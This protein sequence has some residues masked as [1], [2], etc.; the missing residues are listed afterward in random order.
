MLP[1]LP[2]QHN[3]IANKLEFQSQTVHRINIYN[4][5]A[6]NL[7][8]GHCGLDRM[9]VGFITTYAINAYHHLHCEFEPLSGKVHLIQNYVIKFV[10]DLW[11]V[12]GF[13]WVLRFPQQI[14]TYHHDITEILLKVAL[15]TINHQTDYYILTSKGKYC[16]QYIRKHVYFYYTI[17]ELKRCKDGV[18]IIY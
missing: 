4:H 15:N 5:R 12:G 7:Y 16:T 11:Q 6:S 10:S 8:R 18:L 9:V 2:I 3:N 1:N 17:M 14:K 13:L